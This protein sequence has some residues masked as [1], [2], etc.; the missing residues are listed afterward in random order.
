ML[1]VL[2]EHHRVCVRRVGALR[3]GLADGCASS[4]GGVCAASAAVVDPDD[5]QSWD[6]WCDARF[7]WL[8]EHPWQ[9]LGGLDVIDVIFEVPASQRLDPDD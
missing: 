7:H 2:R 3:V 1:D 8:L 9:L 5:W 4:A 6:Q